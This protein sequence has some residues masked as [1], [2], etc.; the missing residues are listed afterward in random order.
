VIDPETGAPARTEL[1]QASVWAPTCAEAE[2]AAT[3]ALLLG[4]DAARRYPAV[5][6]TRSAEI[7]I[8]M[9]VEGVAA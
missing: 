9:P 5:L 4:P 6:V 1:L 2:V 3:H 7:V 8:S